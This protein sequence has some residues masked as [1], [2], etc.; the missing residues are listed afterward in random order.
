MKNDLLIRADGSTEIGLGHLVRCMSLAQI[1]EE[2]YN[3]EF[4]CKQIPEKI[5]HE[6]KKETFRLNKI[7]D[8]SSFLDSLNSEITVV[9]DGYHFDLQYQK[10]IKQSG[11]KLVI[12]DDLH[13]HKFHADLIINHAPGVTE[14]DYSAEPYT[15]FALGPDYALLRSSFLQVAKKDRKARD[16]SSIFICFGGSDV[17]NLTQSVYEVVCNFDQFKKI[18]IVTG[19]AYK[20]HNQILKHVSKDDKV[21]YHHAI[22]EEMMLELML[23]SGIAFV[24]CSGI[25]FEALASGN[26]CISGIYNDNQ[27]EVY[28]GFK[29]LNAIIDSGT[30]K[31]EQIEQSIKQIN[32]FQ[33]KKVIDGK[34]PERFKTLF[35]KL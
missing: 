14:N 30:F 15:K 11:S 20:F 27:Q 13:S 2:D 3:I 26:I 16:N 28:K 32:D 7:E 35:R 9:L 12:I 10:K 24:P 4:V 5:E 31:K 34:S 19:S 25:L 33:I 29:S 1:L 21:K 6:L 18:N 23:T 17:K 22:D 8:D